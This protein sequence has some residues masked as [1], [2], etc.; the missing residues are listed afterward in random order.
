[1]T[2]KAA[3][4]ARRA[5]LKGVTLGG[6]AVAATPTAARALDVKPKGRSVPLA[7]NPALEIAEFTQASEPSQGGSGSPASG[8]KPLYGSDYMVDA[9][10][11]LDVNVIAE[12]PGNT[13]AGLHESI[14][15]RGMLAD[16]PTEMLTVTHEEISVAFAHGYT[17]VSGELSAAMVHSTVGLQH[18]SM[19]IYNAWCD[20]APVL[21]ITGSLTNPD[22]RRSYVDWLHGVSDG[23]ALTRDFTKFDETPRTLD[24]FRE[25]LTRCYQM[26]MTPPHGPVVLALD[27]DLQEAEVEESKIPRPVVKPR[28]VPPQGELGAVREIA[29]ILANA[30]TPVIVA[31]RAIHSAQGLAAMVELAELLGAAV[32]D[33]GGRMNFPWR[34]PLNQSSNRGA[35]M[36]E[37]D[38]VLA[39]EVQDVAG[40]VRGASKARTISIS[41]YDFY[42]KSNYQAFMALPEL[43]MAIAGDAEATLPSLIEEVRKAIPSAKRSAIAARAGKWANEHALQ[44]ERSRQAATLGWDITPI[45]TSRVFAEVHDQVRDM[46]WAV[47]GGCHFEGSWPKHLWDAKHHWQFIGDSGGMGLGYLPGAAVGA[48][49]AHKQHG[50]LPIVFGGDGDL[51]MAPGALFTA[52]YHEIPILY[53]V[54]NNGGYHQEV[55]KIQQQAGRRN[56]GIRR[57]HIGNVLPDVDYGRIAQGMGVHGQRVTE[58]GDLRAAIAR[59]LDV[60]ANGEPALIDVVS[61]GR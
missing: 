22:A 6:L 53:L 30:E 59:A 56:R 54:H 16:P 51:M 8:T 11:A 1:M 33:I 18:A 43:D 25:S 39:L 28:I 58:P 23:P 31:D 46:D 36:R 29:Q 55:M 24:H 44:L 2:E 61:Q 41:T 48:A 21:T 50:R 37:A 60:I 47:V 49:H 38:V 40:A 12:I 15:N 5:V 42:L 27:L 20:R 34:H 14:V 3:Y 9:L 13:F 19:A 52:G 10:R 7:P 45:T 17:K 57:S 26:A 32:I 35:P 4:P